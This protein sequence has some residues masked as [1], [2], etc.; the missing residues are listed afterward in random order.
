LLFFGGSGGSLSD[1]GRRQKGF[2]TSFLLSGYVG[3]ETVKDEWSDQNVDLRLFSEGV[4]RFFVDNKFETKLERFGSGFKIEAVN[5]HFRV[6][7]RVFGSPEF[8]KVEFVP[9]RKT[10][11]FSLGMV[12]GYV[13]SVFGG[14]GL[15]LRD[16]R[17]QEAMSEF[18]SLFWEYVDKQVVELRGSAVVKQS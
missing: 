9:G 4:E 10:S 15:F 7:V 8:F 3:I 14:G 11:G 13:G 18:E 16:V 2:K 17:L 5:V 6:N 1:V 12:L